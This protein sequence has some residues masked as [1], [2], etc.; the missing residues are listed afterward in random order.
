MTGVNPRNIATKVFVTDPSPANFIQWGSPATFPIRAEVQAMMGD[1]LTKS[2]RSAGVRM[3][4]SKGHGIKSR[5][6]ISW[7]N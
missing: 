6:E 2:A 3:I 4:K 7:S 5:E 1:G